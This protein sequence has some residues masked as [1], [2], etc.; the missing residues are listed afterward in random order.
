MKFKV[1]P[2][3]PI[4][5]K[6]MRNQNN[7]SSKELAYHIEKSFSYVSKLESGDVKN[8]LEEDLTKILIFINGGGDLFED[9][10]PQVVRTLRS[11]CPPEE[12]INQL[13]L[14]HYDAAIRPV[15]LP[16][17]MIDD[18]NEKLN[19]CNTSYEQF[20][21]Q[22][23][24]NADSELSE[25]FAPNEVLALEHYGK[26]RIMMR[27]YVQINQ[28]EDIFNKVNTSTTYSMVQFIVYELHR[29]MMYPKRESKLASEQ[30]RE[31]L[32]ASAAYMDRFNIHSLTNFAHLLSSD[33]YIDNMTGG[34]N[35][36]SS[37]NTTNDFA[38]NELIK[39]LNE[40]IKHEPLRTSQAI[41]NLRDNF[42]WDA[43]FTLSVM[44]IPFNRLETLSYTHKK[45][46]LKQ[47]NKLFEKYE[48]MSDFEKKFE[49]Y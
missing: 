17:E 20:A 45:D 42:M 4:V 2:Q 1:T 21:E 24:K 19:S 30:A 34:I 8:L 14:F 29:L 40:A 37:L 22:I 12:M 48:A 6:T 41:D 3:L 10:L 33:E 35:V 15:K 27:S 47:I 49:L 43:S 38:L 16:D 36:V 9:V 39:I 5:I 46:M 28:I 44:S 23:N 31:V 32:K 25:D 11:F 26:T 18:M 7:I 13:W